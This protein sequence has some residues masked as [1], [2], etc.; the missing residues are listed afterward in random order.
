MPLVQPVLIGT[1]PDFFREHDFVILYN[2]S[3]NANSVNPFSR[4]IF[5]FLWFL[6]VYFLCKKKFNKKPH[7]TMPGKLVILYV[8]LYIVF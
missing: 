4:C 5:V 7:N 2:W 6:N 8:F 3:S 1:Q